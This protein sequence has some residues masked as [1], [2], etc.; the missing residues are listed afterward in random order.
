MVETEAH[1]A[2]KIVAL[3]LMVAVLIATKHHTRQQYGTEYDDL[4]AVL[5]ENFDEAGGFGY[6]YDA[7]EADA[8]KKKR[9]NEREEQ[10][11]ELAQLSQVERGK[12]DIT[13]TGEEYHDALTERAPLLPSAHRHNPS[14]ET[15]ILHN[16]L[17]RPSL[18][19]PLIIIHSVSPEFNPPQSSDTCDLS[20]FNMQL[21]RC[22]LGF[23]F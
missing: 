21:S 3:R 7:A 11:A 1:L 13:S 23:F 15:I 22:S 12:R 17:S 8:A 9:E 19:L 4:R 18:P 2:C 5:P 10:L 14:S 6:G 16:Y 20:I